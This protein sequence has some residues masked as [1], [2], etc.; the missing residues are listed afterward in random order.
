MRTLFKFL[1]PMMAVF[2][3]SGIAAA[4]EEASSKS[5][6]E[7]A[8]AVLQVQVD[9]PP[10]WDPWLADDLSEA[11]FNRVRHIFIRHE[12]EGTLKEVRRLNEPEPDEPLLSLQVYRWEVDRTGSVRCVIRGDL[13]DAER[14]R[15]RL[16][17][18]TATE[19][20]WGPANQWE[21]A[22]TFVEAADDVAEQLWNDLKEKDL[23]D[24]VLGE[25]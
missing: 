19:F 23:L 7:S 16:G 21:L 5:E 18:Y 3:V 2:A 15:T 25:R 6:S 13:Y 24:K 14:N 11:L 17:V 10:A 8:E 12:F 9:V 22:D 1:V 4:A 20:V